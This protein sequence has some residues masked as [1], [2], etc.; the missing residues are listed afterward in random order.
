M[1]P[2]A[3]ALIGTADMQSLG[4]TSRERYFQGEVLLRRGTFRELFLPKPGD[5]ILRR[6]TSTGSTFKEGRVRYSQ[7]FPKNS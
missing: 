5:L 7:G 4:G 2:L 6:G 1:W 3:A